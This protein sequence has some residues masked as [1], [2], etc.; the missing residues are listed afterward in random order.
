MHKAKIPI[1]EPGTPE[2]STSHNRRALTKSN[3]T[4][5]SS[6][7]NYHIS[8]IT[9][10]VDFFVEIPDNPSKSFFA[11]N[12]FVGLKDSIFEGS[13]PLRHVVELFAAMNRQMDHV[14]PYLSIFSDGGGDHNIKFIFV[15]C[16]LLALF[17][18]GDFDVLNAGRC[19]PNQSYI[20]PAERCMSLLN[21]GLQGKSWDNASLLIVGIDLL[22]IP[23]QSIPI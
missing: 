23:L 6:D 7:H 17:K 18:I 12:V 13:D 14:P 2:A 4:L 16:A 10:S 20:N 5:E 22:S 19:A 15:K 1:G 11:G 21:I 8:N 9:P 3:I